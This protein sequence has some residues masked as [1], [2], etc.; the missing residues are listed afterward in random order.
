MLCT[1]DEWNDKDVDEDTGEGGGGQE[2]LKTVISV[3][4]TAVRTLRSPIQLRLLLQAS[5][6]DSQQVLFQLTHP[7]S[8]LGQPPPHLLPLL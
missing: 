7:V 4:M 2:I 5:L 3:L 6:G 1:A 8:G